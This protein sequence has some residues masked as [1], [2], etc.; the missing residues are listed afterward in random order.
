MQTVPKRVNKIHRLFLSWRLKLGLWFYWKGGIG[1]K[2]S[3]AFKRWDIFHRLSL[4]RWCSASPDKKTAWLQKRKCSS[5][6]TSLVRCPAKCIEIYLLLWWW[7][8]VSISAVVWRKI[9][10]CLSLQ[11]EHLKFWSTLDLLTS[12]PARALRDASS[13]IGLQS[14]SFNAKFFLL[15]IKILMEKRQKLE[16]LAART[17]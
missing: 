9:K 8:P 10:V 17:T 5:W 4:L 7:S 14:F 6:V 11:P 12:Y 1:F 13:I 2:C 3:V 15:S 16:C